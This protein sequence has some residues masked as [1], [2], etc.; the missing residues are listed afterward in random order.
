MAKDETLNGGG[1]GKDPLKDAITGE[2]ESKDYWGLK[3]SWFGFC[4][5]VCLFTIQRK[6]WI[7]QEEKWPK[8]YL[9]SCDNNMSP[10]TLV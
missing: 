9:L 4:L 3:Q 6:Q 10:A 1:Q 5:F 7:Y 8:K 2:M